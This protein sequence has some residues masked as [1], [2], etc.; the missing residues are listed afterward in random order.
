MVELQRFIWAWPS[1]VERF[2]AL[3]PAVGARLVRST[4]PLAAERRPDGKLLLILGCWVAADRLFLHAPDVTQLLDRGF[5]QLLGE[6]MDVLVTSWPAGDGEPNGPPD[7]LAGLPDSLRDAGIECG[8]TLHRS[9]FAAAARR[10]LVF[11]CQY[12]VL[13]YRLD[14]ALPSL[15]IG[16]EIGG[17]EWRSWT[18]PAALDRRER[19]QSLGAEGWTVRWFTGQEILDHL[20]RSLDEVACLVRQRQLRLPLDL[21]RSS[22]LNGS[23][24]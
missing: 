6:T 19:E 3:N 5:K 24:R 11:E 10:G 18:H 8:G 13:S 12:P 17:W 7:P 16:I 20:E 9:F 2:C 22:Y 4:R 21:P 23:G 1:L 14:F 15:R